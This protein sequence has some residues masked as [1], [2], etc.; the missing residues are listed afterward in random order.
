MPRSWPGFGD[1]GLRASPHKR[2]PK[3][4]NSRTSAHVATMLSGA[5]NLMDMKEEDFDLG[6]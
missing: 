3:L 5:A 6:Y 4:P 2:S 1:K